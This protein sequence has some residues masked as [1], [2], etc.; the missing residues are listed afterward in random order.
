M[1]T[2]RANCLSSIRARLR[3]D[4][5]WSFIKDAVF[6]FPVP[7]S[8]PTTPTG[9]PFLSSSNKHFQ[10]L[11]RERKNT[12]LGSRG[13]LNHVKIERLSCYIV[14]LND[15]VYFILDILISYLLVLVGVQEDTR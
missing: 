9:F 1:T 12:E 15:A 4:D 11:F 14:A 2:L 13:W 8:S 5:W 3:F 7:F 10:I 6:D